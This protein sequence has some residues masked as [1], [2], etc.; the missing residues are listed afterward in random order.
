MKQIAYLSMIFLP[1]SFV[2]VRLYFIFYVFFRLWLLQ[3]VF[4]MNVKELS[5]QTLGTL[6]HYFAAAFPLTAVTVWIVI[7]FQS[8]HLFKNRETSSFWARL[9]WPILMFQSLFSK[10][11]KTRTSL[12]SVNVLNQW[13][14][15]QQRRRRSTAAAGAIY[16]LP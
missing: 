5:A 2:A 16:E 11:K 10:S 9:A 14:T 8:K 1:A 4:G 3:G 13:N 12:S 7:A 6:P 15:N